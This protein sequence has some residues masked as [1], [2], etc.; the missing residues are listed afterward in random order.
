MRSLRLVAL[1]DDGKHLVLAG[2]GPTDDGER[3]ELPI[4]DRL[5]AAARGD[6]PPATQIDARTPTS[7]RGSS[8]RG[9]GPARP[10][11][12]SRTPPAP[13][14]SGSCGSPTRCCRSAPGSPS[15]PATPASGCPRA[16][17]ACRWSSSCPSGCGCSAPTWTPSAGT[18]TAAR[19]APGRSRGAWRA[20]HKSGTTRWTYDIPARTVTP[21]DATTMDFAEGTRLVRV[22]P[23]VPVG[24]PAAP[25]SRRSVASVRRRARPTPRTTS[26]P[27]RPAGRRRGAQRRARPTATR[28]TCCCPAT[29]APTARPADAGRRRAPTTRS[30]RHP[31]HRRARPARRR[32]G[33][34]PARPHPGLGGHRL[35]GPPAPLRR[36]PPRSET[37]RLGHNLRIASDCHG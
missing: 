1:S 18:P 19:T 3:F 24:L 6:A 5:R 7:R 4:D 22:V 28:S 17:P 16:P 8:R 11:S 21:V 29:T 23:D 14:S 25:I 27:R 33:R 15:R 30:T 2:T 31:G 10:P 20:G 9:S 13:A 35:R 26:T 34:G 32:R 36:R 12:R 37:V